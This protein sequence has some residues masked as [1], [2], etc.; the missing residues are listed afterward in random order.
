MSEVHRAI[1]DAG[2]RVEGG[3]QPLAQVSGEAEELVIIPVI[4][5]ISAIALDT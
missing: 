1:R 3:Q 4:G 2:G 5:V